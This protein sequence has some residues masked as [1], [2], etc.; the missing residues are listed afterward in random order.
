ME[1]GT[2]LPLIFTVKFITLLLIELNF[3]LFLLRQK[4][5]VMGAL[6]AIFVWAAGIWGFYK[7]SK[8]N[9]GGWGPY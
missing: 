2:A 6:I 9:P 1:T 4:Q 7:W 5:V 8:D 3:Y